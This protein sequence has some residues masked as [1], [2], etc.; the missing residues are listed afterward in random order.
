MLQSLGAIHLN[1][2][3]TIGCNGTEITQ[4]PFCPS[5]VPGVPMGC[6]GLEVLG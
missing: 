5:L 3:W 1:G 4:T 6:A 2:V